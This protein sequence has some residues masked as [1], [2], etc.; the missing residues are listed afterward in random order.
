MVF[1]L[2]ETSD[3][4]GG[5]GDMPSELDYLEIIGVA[6][7]ISTIS[8]LKAEIQETALKISYMSILPT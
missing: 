5:N 8:I 6:F 7:R 3:S 2:P 1:P 4:N